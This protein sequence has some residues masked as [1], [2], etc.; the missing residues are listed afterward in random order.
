[1]TFDFR[2]FEEGEFQYQLKKCKWEKVINNVDVNS[3][4]A[5]FIYIFNGKR[6]K[7]INN[8]KNRSQ[9]I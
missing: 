8:N 4:C 5:T 1:M 2:N 7:Y 3:A 6:Q 9:K